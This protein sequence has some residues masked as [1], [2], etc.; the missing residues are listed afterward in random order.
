MMYTR[1]ELMSS[2]K[3]V[4]AGK[5]VDEVTEEEKLLNNGGTQ[6]MI[7]FRKGNVAA[8]ISEDTF[9]SAIENGESLDEAVRRICASV[10]ASLQD[11]KKDVLSSVEDVYS[12]TDK[13]KAKLYVKLVN[14]EKNKEKLLSVPH[15]KLLD[16]AIVMRIKVMEKEDGI[17]SFEVTRP[18]AGMSLDEMF[19]AAIKNTSKLFEPVTDKLFNFLEA[20]F[21]N[22]FPDVSEGINDFDTLYV[23]TNKLDIDGAHILCNDAKL[24]ELGKEI[25]S[26]FILPCSIH[27]VLA[28]S[29]R[30]SFG[31]G[32]MEKMVNEANRTAVLPS[33]F[34]SDSVYFY[35]ADTGK[36]SIA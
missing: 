3:R 9:F 20:K 12:D 15:K 28:I 22:S 6:K 2:V 31:K 5:D 19:S 25:G 8:N 29:S 11:D 14:Y 30:C 16:L 34:L 4:I 1:E 24:Q 27:E 10:L 21:G 13:L 32:Y 23:L 7:R 35:N 17:S 26:Y 36:L 18:M 33:E